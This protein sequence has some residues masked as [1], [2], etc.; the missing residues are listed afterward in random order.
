MRDTTLVDILIDI[1]LGIDNGKIPEHYFI[2]VSAPK[3][4]HNN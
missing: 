1:Q 3:V 2:L 4:N